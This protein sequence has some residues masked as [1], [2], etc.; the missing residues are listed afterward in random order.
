MRFVWGSSMAATGRGTDFPLSL[1]H[2]DPFFLLHLDPKALL[3]TR[4][5][6]PP[7]FEVL[8][9]QSLPLP[10]VPVWNY[11]AG[12]LGYAMSPVPPSLSGVVATSY[13][14]RLVRT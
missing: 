1:L 3:V 9:P 6:L 7:L 4:R 8:L 12:Y 11:G 10:V 13:V 14:P 2:L 5:F